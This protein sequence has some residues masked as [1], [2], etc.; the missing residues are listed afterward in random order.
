M[1]GRKWG[2]RDA[3]KGVDRNGCWG[4]ELQGE[5]KKMQEKMGIDPCE[6]RKRKKNGEKKWVVDWE[7]QSW[8]GE[9]GRK[10]SQNGEGR[11]TKKNWGG[12]MPWEQGKR[13]KKRKEKMMKSAD[14]RALD[15]GVWR[16]GEGRQGEEKEKERGERRE[17]RENK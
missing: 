16:V 9:K 13:N 2:W 8:K 14:W 17:E 1:G 3:G 4:G 6:R 5:E 10:K 7:C 15:M 11:G 12:T